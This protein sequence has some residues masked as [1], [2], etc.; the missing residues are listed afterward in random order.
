[1]KKISAFL[2]IRAGKYPVTGEGNFSIQYKIYSHWNW[3]QNVF[4]AGTAYKYIAHP[5]VRTL[6][7]L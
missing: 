6:D 4:S 2:A 1:M 7:R 3:S 5:S